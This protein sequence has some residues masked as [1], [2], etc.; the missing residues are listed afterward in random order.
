MG[1]ELLELSPGLKV[2]AS[3][4]FDPPRTPL[5][6]VHAAAPAPAALPRLLRHGAP[7]DCP[8]SHMLQLQL[9]TREAWHNMLQGSLWSMLASSCLPRTPAQS[10]LGLS[11]AHAHFCS[12]RPAK[13]SWHRQSTQGMLSHKAPPSRLRE[14][15]GSPNS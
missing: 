14:V 9:S 11:S 10:A 1:R 4:M 5:Q 15:A 6:P 2:P 12:S 8:S 7:Q 3:A 13:A